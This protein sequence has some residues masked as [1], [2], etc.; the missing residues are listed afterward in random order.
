MN[1]KDDNTD[2]VFF[3]CCSTHLCISCFNMQYDAMHSNIKCHICRR[4][5]F[6]SQNSHT[7]YFKSQ[8]TIQDQ[9]NE[10]TASNTNIINLSTSFFNIDCLIN[11]ININHQPPS[12]LVMQ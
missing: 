10:I 3:N 1:D 2:Q 5:Q 4:Q 11:Y 9:I 7:L 6:I 12:T 8:Q